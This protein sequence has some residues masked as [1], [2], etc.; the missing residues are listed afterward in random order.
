MEN[1]NETALYDGNYCEIC[2]ITDT[3]RIATKVCEVCKLQICGYEINHIYDHDRIDE[4][5]RSK[6]NKMRSNV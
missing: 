1:L 3:L 6:S 4:N 2:M 5:H